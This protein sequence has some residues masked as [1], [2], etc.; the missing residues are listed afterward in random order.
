[1]RDAVNIEP[2]SPPRSPSIQGDVGAKT[3]SWFI[4][5]SEFAAGQT[6]LGIMMMLACLNA[7][8]FSGLEMW[9]KLH[10]DLCQIPT[11][12]MASLTQPGNLHNRSYDFFYT[13]ISSM[14]A[15]WGFNNRL[16]PLFSGLPNRV[17]N[18]MGSWKA[19]K[20]TTYP[21]G[22]LSNEQDIR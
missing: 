10:G 12:G 18:S 19:S 6:S 20:P 3:T 5:W 13:K 11:E 9:N 22:G 8:M 21:A 15:I 14:I 7:Q 16:A 1:M 17:P 2:R 4:C